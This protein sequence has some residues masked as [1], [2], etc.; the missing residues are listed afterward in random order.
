MTKINPES[1]TIR[2]STALYTSALARNHPT[3]LA[4]NDQHH[5]ELVTLL[6]VGKRH[7]CR[8]PNSARADAP[9]LPHGSDVAGLA[10]CCRNE[11]FRRASGADDEDPTRTPAA[12]MIMPVHS[13]IH[14]KSR[15][16]SCCQCG[17]L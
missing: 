14:A 3:L 2:E 12:W 4:K 8:A 17:S 9:V 1:P 6:P 5:T 10:A 7:S 16:K 11:R 15:S 13:L